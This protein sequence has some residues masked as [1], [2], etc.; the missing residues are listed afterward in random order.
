MEK[1]KELITTKWQTDAQDNV[2]ARSEDVRLTLSNAVLDNAM[3]LLKE[4]AGNRSRVVFPN[5]EKVRG[6]MGCGA[7]V[8]NYDRASFTVKVNMHR[9]GADMTLPLEAVG[10]DEES[11]PWLKKL[12]IDDQPKPSATPKPA[13]GMVPGIMPGMMPGMNPMMMQQQMQIQ[14]Q[15]QMQMQ[16][17]MKLLVVMLVVVVVV[18][19]VEVTMMKPIKNQK[20]KAF[21]TT[22]QC[23]CATWPTTRFTRA[24]ETMM[25]I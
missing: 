24:H 2:Y 9:D 22:K 21:C 16:M 23:T 20:L 15:M 19:V 4:R 11:A 25:A 17:K 7:E 12:K 5:V 13:Q 18:L 6:Y 10:K 14:M 3:K 1:E 8:Q